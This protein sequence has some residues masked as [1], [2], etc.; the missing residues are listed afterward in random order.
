MA[1]LSVAVSGAGCLPACKRGLRHAVCFKGRIQH[2]VIACTDC[3]FTGFRIEI[4]L[5][6][7]MEFHIIAV[8]GQRNPLIVSQTVTGEIAPAVAAVQ[9]RF[10]LAALDR[11]EKA[12]LRDMRKIIR[13]V[14]D[15]PVGIRPVDIVSDHVIAVRGVPA[16]QIRG[17]EIILVLVF[18]HTVALFAA[19]FFYLDRTFR[20]KEIRLAQLADILV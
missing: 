4:P 12:G 16:V 18:E 2:I 10:L 17:A 8:D 14:H 5:A 1:A 11:I 13:A 20:G 6:Q 7:R 3:P 9:H 15:L 19:A